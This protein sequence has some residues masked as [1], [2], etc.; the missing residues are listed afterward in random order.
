VGVAARTADKCTR[1]VERADNLLISLIAT[2]LNEGESIHRLMGSLAAQ[3]CLPDE[4]VIVDGGSSD[5]TV[6]I[7]EGYADKL[8]LRV[9][10]EP[11][12]N[13]SEG[14]NR[15][16]AAAQGD[17]IAV[18]DAGVELAPDWLEKLVRPLLD[19]AAVQV[20]G[21]FFEAE[22]TNPFELAMGATVLPL[23]DEI[24]PATFL[25]SSRSVAFRK[26]MWAAVG[27]YPEWLDYC[28]D[29]VFDLRLKEVARRQSPVTSEKQSGQNLTRLE[30]GNS[31]L[32]T[33]FAFVPDAVVAFRPR[34]SLRS[35]FK[36]YYLYARGDG[37]A[38]LWRKR[39]VARYLT[40]LVAAPFI[41]SA[42]VAIHPLLWLLFI[43]GAVYYLRQPYRRLGQLL[44]DYRT[45][46]ALSLQDQVYM[47]AC[48]PVIRVVGDIAK[49]LGYPVGVVWRLRHHPPDWRHIN[50]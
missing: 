11:G 9:L 48:V 47:L 7:M 19:N 43:P 24:N 28:E 15:A 35:F 2:V 27:G 17:I 6:S 21:G 50:T 45:R 36:Q 18:T 5:N 34:G 42:G 23:A 16:I 20:S 39:Q 8:P 30:T 46:H 38:D 40:Y 26:P 1:V 44:R 4:V 32:A 29:L 12:C 13:I 22:A 10:V 49:M 41:L 31:R 37:K 33:T 14:R 3:T 25:P